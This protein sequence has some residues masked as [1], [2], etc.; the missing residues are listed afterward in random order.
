MSTE[1]VTEADIS[2]TFDDIELDALVS[3]LDEDSV[4][5]G[6]QQL[7]M[8][9]APCSSSPAQPCSSAPE[10]EDTGTELDDLFQ[11]ALEFI[12]LPTQSMLEPLTMAT[13][14]E[15][16]IGFVPEL[17]VSNG[18]PNTQDASQ[19]LFQQLSEETLQ[20]LSCYSSQLPASLPLT[21]GNATSTDTVAQTVQLH[22]A[23]NNSMSSR[24]T[25][26]LDP[27]T[28]ICLSNMEPAT[29][30][31]SQEAQM[32]AVNHD[33]CYTA[34]SERGLSSS[35]LQSISHASATGQ[36]SEVDEGNS[37]DGGKGMKGK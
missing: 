3:L 10:A 34:L 35:S 14:K 18:P 24:L 31:R 37:S 1:P 15:E 16:D 26:V 33:H 6:L 36:S 23:T 29:D 4:L 20:A 28:G 13:G 12:A 22:L 2:A 7:P 27:N 9:A 21:S 5:Q 25:P 8:F 30:D 17:S 11:D 32:T 19:S